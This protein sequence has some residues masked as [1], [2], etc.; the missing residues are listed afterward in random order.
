MH[1]TQLVRK[2]ESLTPEDK[3]PELTRL[4][5]EL[6]GHLASF[7]ELIRKI[8]LTGVLTEEIRRE[9]QDLEKVVQEV[10]EKVLALL[11]PLE[12]LFRLKESYE[13][14][15]LRYRTLGWL[16][17]QDG[18]EGIIGL[19]Q[20]FYPMPSFDAIQ[21]ALFE[22]GELLT[23]KHSQGF[24]KFMLVPFGM[25]YVEMYNKLETEYKRYAEDD[26]LKL[27]GTDAVQKQLTIIEKDP[28]CSFDMKKEAE[29]GYYPETL[30]SDDPEVHQAKSKAELIA[31]SATRFPGWEI[32]LIPENP[33][34][35]RKQ[36][37]K[38]PEMIGDR[39]VFESECDFG[40]YLEVMK[41]REGQNL[42]KSGNKPKSVKD[43]DGH[44]VY[45]GEVGLIPEVWA[46]WALEEL[47]TNK[48]VLHDWNSEQDTAAVLIGTLT[49]V[50]SVA[51]SSFDRNNDQVH[52]LDYDTDHRYGY[53]SGVSSVKVC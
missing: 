11:Y 19:D 14:Q 8:L 53:F 37:D 26:T 25:S 39:P 17:E 5:Q 12:K 27:Y 7:K 29:L 43:S 24:K 3:T 47:Y 13:T 46:A 33:L 28:Y 15:V 1:P 21:E 40:D 23:Y 45:R 49:K 52:L 20:N 50:Y 35:A 44:N 32:H 4:E 18:K 34:L 36:K 41:G 30:Y 22:Q 51:V 31:D 10:A 9:R 48:Q 2:L 6:R 16:M 38:D 42:S